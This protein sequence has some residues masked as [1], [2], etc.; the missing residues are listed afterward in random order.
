MP[1][2]RYLL[3]IGSIY[4]C[5]YAA[6]RPDSL[7][8]FADAPTSCAEGELLTAPDARTQMYECLIELQSGAQAERNNRQYGK[9]FTF[10]H[11]TYFHGFCALPFMRKNTL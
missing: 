1:K 5:G 8:K 3:S 6:S 4:I 9:A 7:S 2:L 11:S 10:M